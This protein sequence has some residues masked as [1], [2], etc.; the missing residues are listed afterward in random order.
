MQGNDNDRTWSKLSFNRS[1]DTRNE[2]N[3]ESVIR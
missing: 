1:K 3:R 2:M